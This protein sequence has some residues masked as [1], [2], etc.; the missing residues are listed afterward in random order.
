MQETPLFAQCK[1]MSSIHSEMKRLYDHQLFVE[2]FDFCKGHLD[3][4]GSGPDVQK[5]CRG[6]H[7]ILTVNVS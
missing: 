5:W 1:D 7:P 6:K 4:G 2:L 3:I